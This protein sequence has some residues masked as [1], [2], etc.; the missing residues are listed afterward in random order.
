M[1][2]EFLDGVLIEKFI[3]YIQQEEANLLGMT[4]DEIEIFINR[5][6]SVR[7]EFIE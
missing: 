5:F 4:E 7:G 1:S 3:T 6:L 2:K